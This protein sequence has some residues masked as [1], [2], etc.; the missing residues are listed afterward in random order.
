MEIEQRYL[1]GGYTGQ[2]IA[3]DPRDDERFDWTAVYTDLPNL[4]PIP[5]EMYRTSPGRAVERD[6][7]FDEGYPPGVEPDAGEDE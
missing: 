3:F 6:D 1:A 4:R 2:E 7:D 5:E